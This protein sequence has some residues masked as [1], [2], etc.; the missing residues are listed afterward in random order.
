M[1]IGCVRECG[2]KITKRMLEHLHYAN[3]THTPDGAPYSKTTIRAAMA[4]M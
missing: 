2:G 3:I 1:R 4:G